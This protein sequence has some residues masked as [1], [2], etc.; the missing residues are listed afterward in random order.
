M[1]N[2]HMDLNFRVWQLPP[3]SPI[4]S[5]SNPWSLSPI[6]AMAHHAQLR[7]R[8]ALKKTQT[9]LDKELK[10]SVLG[11]HRRLYEAE[12]ILTGADTSMFLKWILEDALGA[13][14]E[15]Y[16]QRILKVPTLA[17]IISQAKSNL[18]KDVQS[19]VNRL[20]LLLATAE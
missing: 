8:L 17:E 12:F 14:S 2:P 13:V 3:S 11:I 20:M 16:E 4:N 7:A 15:L 6:P 5:S 9:E 1:P 18:I 10:T 19:R